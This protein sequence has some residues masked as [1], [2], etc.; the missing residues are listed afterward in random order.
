[1]SIARIST[2]SN[3]TPSQAW[4]L[5]T[6]VRGAFKHCPVQTHTALMALL[7]STL[8]Y[9]DYNKTI[10]KTEDFIDAVD[11]LIVQFPV[12]K[13]EEWKIVMTRLKAGHYGKTYERLQL[14]EL[15]E[16]FQKYEEDRAIMIE[17]NLARKKDEP[18]EPLSEE[19]RDIIKKLMKDLDLPEP[20]DEKGRWTHIHHPNVTEEQTNKE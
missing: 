5:G 9:L 1:M 14:P 2:R 17:K 7:K 20:P 3:I 13:I 19:Q 16:A 18:I 15:V 8:D 10:R 6:N 11:Y 12:M 4:E